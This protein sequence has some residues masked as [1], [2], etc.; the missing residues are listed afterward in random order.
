MV[1]ISSTAKATLVDHRKAA[2][3]NLTPLKASKSTACHQS[4]QRDNK[5][6]VFSYY[7]INVPSNM[8]LQEGGISL[9]QLLLLL[10]HQ[11][12]RHQLPQPLIGICAVSLCLF[13]YLGYLS[14]S[15]RIFEC[16]VIVGV[17]H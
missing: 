15:F 5:L 11:I 17:W 1:L 14:A 4:Y 9:Q 12:A 3:S 2:W 6:I 7:R 10:S 8:L 16:C 13:H